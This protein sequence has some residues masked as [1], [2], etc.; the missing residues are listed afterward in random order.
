VE[1]AGGQVKRKAFIDRVSPLLRE[2][3]KCT[4]DAEVK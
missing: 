1:G 4:M 3:L 2:L